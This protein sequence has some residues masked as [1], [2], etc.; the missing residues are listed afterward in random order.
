MD[1]KDLV[2]QLS[3]RSFPPDY[4]LQGQKPHQE[5]VGLGCLLGKVCLFFLGKNASLVTVPKP[6]RIWGEVT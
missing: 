1:L 2:S 6:S 3:Q 5:D 4:T